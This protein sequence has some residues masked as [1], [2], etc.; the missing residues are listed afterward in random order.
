MLKLLLIQPF[1]TE[2]QSDPT[3]L[4]LVSNGSF[5]G[6][7]RAFRGNMIERKTWVRGLC[8]T[9]E[10]SAL[11]YTMKPMRMMGFIVYLD[12]VI[13]LSNIPIL[14]YKYLFLPIISLTFQISTNSLKYDVLYLFIPLSWS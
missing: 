2:R 1:P 4:S 9:P 8:P 7:G 3:S 12:Y 11:G 14:K 13:E 10:F 6:L 5:G